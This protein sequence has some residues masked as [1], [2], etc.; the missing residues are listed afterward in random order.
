MIK[1]INLIALL[2]TGC[3]SPEAQVVNGKF[4]TGYDF[5][6]IVEGCDDLSKF[7]PCYITNGEFSSAIIVGDEA[8]ESDYSAAEQIS[9]AFD[10]YV[11]MGNAIKSDNEV[12]DVSGII[13][14]GRNNDISKLLIPQ[15]NF[16]LDS[17]QGRI[18]LVEF[19]GYMNLLVDGGSDETTS[20]AADI[21]R[22]R[23]DE[24][25]GTCVIVEDFGEGWSSASIRYLE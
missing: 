20:L 5:I 18:C 19:D 13:S 9:N 10:Q 25:S 12:R 17:G 16:G 22:R 21:L 23:Y 11:D 2:T 3:Y 15:L 1:Q 6:N 8:P 14:V 24:L 4:D 7:P